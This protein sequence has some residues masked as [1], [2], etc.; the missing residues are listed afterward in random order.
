MG[1]EG[2]GGGG[3]GGERDILTKVISHVGVKV[4]DFTGQCN[5]LQSHLAPR[6]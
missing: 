6:V 5:M 4:G 1:G 3:G 2:G